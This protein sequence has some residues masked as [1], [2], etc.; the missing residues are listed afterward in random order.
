MER[1]EKARSA[2]A[3][4]ANRVVVSLHLSLKPPKDDVE[5]HCNKYRQNEGNPLSNQLECIHG[6][7]LSRKRVLRVLKSSSNTDSARLFVM[8][9]FAENRKARFNYE[10]MEQFEAGIELLGFEVRAVR[11]GKASLEGAH[12]T[13]RGGEAYI[14]GM[15]IAPYQ[16]GN[17]PESYNQTRNRRLLLTKDEI[18]KLTKA[19]RTKGLTVVPISV[20][21]SKRRIKVALA[22]AR[23][24]KQFDKRETIKKRDD[25]REMRRELKGR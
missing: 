20:Y 7:V 18:E 23:G 5:E 10:F 14:L 9:N 3:D 17:T 11:T 13:M 15:T 21:S 8:S 19:E 22:I 1:K 16:P 6:E 4:R 24:K 12:V 2:S 25:E